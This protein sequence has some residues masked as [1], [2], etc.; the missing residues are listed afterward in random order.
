MLNWFKS[1]W[2]LSTVLLFWVQ[3]LFN[4]NGFNWLGPYQVIDKWHKGIK[5]RISGD[6]SSSI[7][8]AVMTS[9]F[10]KW[11]NFNKILTEKC[12]WK[13]VLYGETVQQ[14]IENEIWN[15]LGDAMK[16]M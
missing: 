13:T 14:Q 7:T 8:R 9:L 15:F 2:V 3:W 11:N 4:S 6:V 10:N 1:T 16:V 12:T 5:G